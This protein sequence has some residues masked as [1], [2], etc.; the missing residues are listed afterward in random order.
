MDGETAAQL[1]AVR[2]ALA[3]QRRAQARAATLDPN[4]ID[5][6]SDDKKAVVPMTDEVGQRCKLNSGVS[7]SVSG[8]QKFPNLM[9]KKLLLFNLEPWFLMSLHPPTTRRGRWWRCKG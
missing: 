6:K 7:E 9:K 8:F 5:R 2:R 1:A 4:E 3:R